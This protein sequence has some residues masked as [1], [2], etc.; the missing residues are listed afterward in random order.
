MLKGIDPR[1]TPDALHALALLGHGDTLVV[2]D[3]NFPAAS[4]AAHTVYK[5][6]V[7][8]PVGANDALE[9]VLS[10]VP[11]DTFDPEVAPVRGMQVVGEPDTV[12]EAVQAAAPLFESADH[13]IELVERHAFYDLTRACFVV[14]HTAETRPYANFIIR[15][16]V[17]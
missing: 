8:L 15:A 7:Y 12:P 2:V 4:V 11:I 17:V 1:L 10:L 16:G 13:R 6:P 3:A 5:R 14:I 9:A